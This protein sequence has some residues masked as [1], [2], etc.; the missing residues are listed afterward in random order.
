MYEGAQEELR[1][2]TSQ[3]DAD[4]MS[5]F[6]CREWIVLLQLRRRYREGQ[7]R[8]TERE[9]AQLRFLRWLCAT[10]HIDL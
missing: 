4:G 2:A 5:T 6:T 3:P 9:L 10:H 7:D 8:W 1:A